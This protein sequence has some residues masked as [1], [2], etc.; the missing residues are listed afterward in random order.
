MGLKYFKLL[1]E[2]V[3]STHKS[4]LMT[5]KS[6]ECFYI[7]F[8]FLPHCEFVPR[9]FMEKLLIFTCFFFVWFSLA[10]KEKF[11]DGKLLNKNPTKMFMLWSCALRSTLCILWALFKIQWKIYESM[12]MDKTN[13]QKLHKYI[14]TWHIFITWIPKIISKIINHFRSYKDFNLIM[15]RIINQWHNVRVCDCG[16][17]KL[18]F[19]LRHVGISLWFSA[20]IPIYIMKNLCFSFA[21]FIGACSEI[22]IKATQNKKRIIIINI[23]FIC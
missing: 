16:R 22:H 4:S 6:C 10:K 12:K 3:C 8:I 13:I 20:S 23:P 9:T 11:Y 1:P 14:S 5:F 17:V 21:L 15:I 7:C 2:S 19:E 18:F